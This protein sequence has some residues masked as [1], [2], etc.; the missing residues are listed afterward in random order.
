MSWKLSI[1]SGPQEGA[2]FELGPQP[3]LIGGNPKADLLLNDPGADRTLLK[4]QTSPETSEEALLFCEP[5]EGDWLDTNAQRK[6]TSEQLQESRLI[7]I[8]ETTL[9]LHRETGMIPYQEQPLAEQSEEAPLPVQPTTNP[10]FARPPFYRLRLAALS[11]SG[12]LLVGGAFHA[13]QRMHSN[14]LRECSALRAEQRYFD[15]LGVMGLVAAIE[16]NRVVVTGVLEDRATYYQLEHQAPPDWSFDW[17]VFV[18]EEARERLS[19]LNAVYDQRITFDLDTSG[20]LRLAALLADAGKVKRL[21]EKLA[22]GFALAPELTLAVHSEEALASHLKS[23]L[24]QN[25]FRSLLSVG[26]GGSGLQVDGLL[27]FSLLSAYH[28]AVDEWREHYPHIALE[29]RPKILTDDEYLEMLVDEPISHVSF[30]SE[31]A[32]GALVTKFGKR[33]CAGAEL[34]SGHSVHK[35]DASTLQIRTDLGDLVTFH[36]A[37]EGLR[38]VSQPAEAA[39]DHP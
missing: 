23:L 30:R 39:P 26:S 35:V 25:G 29:E 6:L 19:L 21:K 17:Q 10:L 4:L 18:V 31:G 12:L 28:R 27:P 3:L 16:G 7:Q 33:Y 14:F 1:R 32:F 20:H 38:A 34:P 22:A 15:Q 8:G 13:L 9:E 5:L 36:Y 11:L 2:T 24:S 37:S